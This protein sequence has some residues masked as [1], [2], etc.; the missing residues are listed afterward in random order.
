MGNPNEGQD[1]PVERLPGETDE[2]YEARKEQVQAQ[3]ESD[4]RDED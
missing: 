4:D 1:Q 3:R 2:Q